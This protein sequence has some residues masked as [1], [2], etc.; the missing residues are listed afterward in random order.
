L[1]SALQKI[2]MNDHINGAMESAIMKSVARTANLCHWLCHPAC[3][4][5]VQQ[6][7]VLSDRCFVPANA[8]SQT[9]EFVA[10]KGVR[11]AYA[12]HNGVNF[13]G[14][15]THA[16]N[17]SVIYQPIPDDAPIAGRNQW[18]ENK[19]DT[20]CLHVRPYQ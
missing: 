12:K 4:K 5:A 13:S 17:A 1:I 18:I 11:C 2:N 7:K 15:S 3:P 20:V 19:G 16:G 9:N 6:L 10:M 14:L 8:L